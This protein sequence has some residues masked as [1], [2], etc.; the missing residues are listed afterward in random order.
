MEEG[1]R[2]GWPDVLLFLGSKATVSEY[3]GFVMDFTKCICKVIGD[4]ENA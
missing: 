2:K 3:L 4:R 1:L